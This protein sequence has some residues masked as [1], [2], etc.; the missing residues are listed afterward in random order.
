MSKTIANHGEVRN[1]DEDNPHTYTWIETEN[2]GGAY[3]RDDGPILNNKEELLSDIFGEQI[4]QDFMYDETYQSINDWD[5][6]G[7]SRESDQ[8]A[9]GEL[10]GRLVGNLEGIWKADLYEAD[11]QNK[12]HEVLLE[13]AKDYP[14]LQSIA[15]DWDRDAED[16]K[17]DY[18]MWDAGKLAYKFPGD[19]EKT[20]F[21]MGSMSDA[22]KFMNKINAVIRKGTGEGGQGGTYVIGQTYTMQGKTYRYTAQG[23]EEIQ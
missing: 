6:S 19:D 5:G 22:E 12:I 3:Q 8:V 11:A 7:I 17:L 23:F 21:D 14:Q 2:G 9:T 18:D 10:S 20:I 4:T 13:A 15:N 16:G 1:L